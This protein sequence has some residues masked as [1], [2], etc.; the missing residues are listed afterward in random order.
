MKT[1]GIYLH[2]PFCLSK[3]PYCDFNSHVRPSGHTTSL[4]DAFF[5]ELTET[6]RTLEEPHRIT[7]VFF[8]G[9]T[10]SLMPPD[11]T[12]RLIDHI[13]T[14]WP[15]DPNWEVSLEANPGTYDQERFEA[16]RKAGINRLSIGIQSFQ[17]TELAFLGRSHSSSDAKRALRAAMHLFPR[18][19]FDLIYALPN[20]SLNVWD[21]TLTEALSYKP[22]HLSCYQLTFEENTPFF[23]KFQRGELYYPQEDA[24][25]AF[26]ELTQKRLAEAGLHSYEISNYAKHGYEC[27]HNL[28]YWNCENF[29]GI[30]PGAH[31]RYWRGKERI[32]T[33]NIRAPEAW[34][35]R[36]L[37]KG[38]GIREREVL[39]QED[40]MEELLLM[41][42]RLTKGLSCEQFYEQTRVTADRLLDSEKVRHLKKAGFLGKSDTHLSLTP[43]G[44]QVANSV[45]AAL[46]HNL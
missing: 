28:I 39:T 8:G 46:A 34:A 25:L 43:K 36:V 41:G 19:S 24:A 10:P 35:E 32:A 23:K 45:I 40:I 33:V 4:E 42:L 6:A 26:Y 16:F 22:T 7:T 13:K 18:V 5:H 29:L 27:R 20:Q 17:D 9:G 30:G 3:C 2:W 37:A 44:R 38:L 1:L 14:L 21:A 31:G 11:L 12:R 15:T